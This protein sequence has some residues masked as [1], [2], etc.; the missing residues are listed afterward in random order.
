MRKTFLMP[1]LELAAL[2]PL[3]PGTY[4]GTLV[5]SGVAGSANAAT[6]PFHFILT[7]PAAVPESATI[8]ML[9]VGLMFVAA[10]L[11]KRRSGSRAAERQSRELRPVRSVKQSVTLLD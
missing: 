8:L 3:I 6:T 10:L 11:R 5:F 9:G 4:N 1:L 2:A 7:V